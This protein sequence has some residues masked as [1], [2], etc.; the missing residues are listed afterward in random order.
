MKAA[1]WLDRVR[2]LRRGA[3]IGLVGC[4]LMVAAVLVADTAGTGAFV[5]RAQEQTLPAAE[6]I[7]EKSIEATGGRAAYERTHS[8]KSTGKM[9]MPAMGLKAEA[10]EYSAVPDLSYMILE[11]PEIG[12]IESGSG[13]D[14]YWEMTQMT[15]PRV[16]EG[17]ERALAR[18]STFNADLRWREFF[19]D[20][21]TA[22]ID[23][24][25]G[26]PCYKLVLIPTEGPVET[27]YYDAGTYLLAKQE[28]LVETPMGEVP[29]EFFPSDYREVGGLLMPFKIRQVLMKM[30]EMVFA[31]DS[32]WFNVEIPES[33]FVF[34]EPIKALLAKQAAPAPE[35]PVEGE[36]P[37]AA[38]PQAPEAEKAPA[39][40]E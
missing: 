18:R 21:S 6:V 34:P 19:P 28:M 9:E 27:R 29:I 17:D 39:E 2:D 15:G 38:A 14:I 16:K 22:G 1:R 36:A 26:R 12:K 5:A 3:G 8:R 10:V 24:V 20:V 23:T 37:P 33:L 32:V 40:T 35:A 31:T 7:L 30:Q 11:S 13:G 25:D 4:V